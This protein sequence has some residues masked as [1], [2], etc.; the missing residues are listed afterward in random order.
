MKHTLLLL[1]AL[2]VPAFAQPVD[3]GKSQ[4]AFTMKQMGVPVSGNFKKFAANVSFNPA[5]PD[6]AKADIGIDIN[7]ISLP[8]ADANNEARK[9]D[10]F[11]AAQFPQAR[12][13]SSSIKPLGNN[14][15]Q[16][17]GKLTIKG[18]TRDV[19]APFQITAQGKQLTVDG[20]LPISRLAF[21]VGEGSWSDTSTVADNVDL[22]FRIVLDN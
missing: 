22:K 17:S 20:L 1:A 9:K 12:F 10:W 8:T 2:S 6:A 18:T 7:S 3:L 14:R 15:F 19:S 21:K 5:Q 13:V 11:N 16:V 4:L